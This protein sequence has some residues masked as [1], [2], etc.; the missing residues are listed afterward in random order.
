MHSPRLEGAKNATL[1]SDR[2]N[3]YQGQA[4]LAAGKET[5]KMQKYCD[6]IPDAT[7]WVYVIDGI[8]SASFYHTDELA[9][10]AARVQLGRYGKDS[11]GMF[12]RLAVNGEMQPIVPPGTRR[13][14]KT[15][16]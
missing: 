15:D 14:G 16:H 1:T 11:S 9:M 12:R 3:F 6:I 10:E 7:G 8:Q 5:L 4:L 2:R 13:P